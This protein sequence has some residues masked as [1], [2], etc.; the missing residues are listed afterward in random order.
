MPKVTSK[1]QITLPKRLAEEYGIAPGDEIEFV[2]AGESSRP[3]HAPAAASA[4][5]SGWVAPE[6]RKDSASGLPD[7]AHVRTARSVAPEALTRTSS[8]S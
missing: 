6:R 7:A 5:P 3:T 1:L 4:S 8:T 2:P